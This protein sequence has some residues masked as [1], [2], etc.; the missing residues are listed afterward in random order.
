ERKQRTDDRNTLTSKAFE[1]LDGTGGTGKAGQG[2]AFQA[3]KEFT[4]KLDQTI[5]NINKQIQE[6]QNEKKN[7][8]KRRDLILAPPVFNT[9]QQLEKENGSLLAR[10][11]TLE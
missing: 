10:L 2:S 8:I 7:L 9:K 3:K 6:L 11:T 1:E 5:N 4:D